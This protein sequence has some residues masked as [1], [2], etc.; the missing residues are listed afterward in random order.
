M[1]RRAI[2]NTVC[3]IC[4]TAG[5]AAM[6]STATNHLAW[7]FE[8]G[9][10]SMLLGLGGFG[11]LLAGGPPVPVPDMP[12]REVFFYLDHDV[13][14]TKPDRWDIVGRDLLDRLSTGRLMAWGRQIG[15][16]NPHSR[17]RASQAHISEED[18]GRASWTYRFFDTGMEKITHMLVK[19]GP[20]EGNT[21]WADVMF[22]RA[23]I[24]KLIPFP[25][26]LW[27]K[28]QFPDMGN[29]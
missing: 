15:R 20:S 3:G 7:L 22:N 18:W 10:A 27:R 12:I 17:I 29:A 1:E 25:E 24:R 19:N 5:A 23:Q 8:V 4:C 26:R 2:I 14:K 16:G 11:A 6:I 9:A 13:L 21:E 28:A